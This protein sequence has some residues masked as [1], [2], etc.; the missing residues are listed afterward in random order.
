LG[1]NLA[2]ECEEKLLINKDLRKSLLQI[3]E[4]LHKNTKAK[5]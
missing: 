5:V 4:L 3:D 2:F 1:K